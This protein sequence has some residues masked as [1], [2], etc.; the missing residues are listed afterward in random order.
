MLTCTE[1][2]ARHIFRQLRLRET[3]IGVRVGVR[4]SGCSGLAYTL[5]VCDDIRETDQVFESHGVKIIVSNI[6]LVFLSGTEIDYARKGLNESLEFRNPKE[7]A[8]CGCG[9]SFTIG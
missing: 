5:E 1:N 2:A 9:E 7:V 8:R 6:D 3:A 4:S